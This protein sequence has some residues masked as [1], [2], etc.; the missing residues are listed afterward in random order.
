[1]MIYSALSYRTPSTEPKLAAVLGRDKGTVLTARSY[2][3]C[4]ITRYLALKK[5]KYGTKFEEENILYILNWDA[6]G[7][8]SGASHLL[9]LAKFWYC[10]ESTKGHQSCL[11]Y[12]EIF[13]SMNLVPE[14]D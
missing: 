6:G 7:S 11:K 4:N 8:L 2:L 13:L 9:C 14:G 12:Q 10:R 1:M 3:I 5:S